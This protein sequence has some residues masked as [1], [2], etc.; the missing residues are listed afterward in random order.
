M[1]DVAV[2]SMDVLELIRLE[3]EH[4]FRLIDT[5]QPLLLANVFEYGLHELDEFLHE[6]VVCE[7]NR[8]VG[9]QLQTFADLTEMIEKE[10]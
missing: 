3:F 5:I 8:M 2:G 9:V 4:L 1:T 10:T 6:F 7:A